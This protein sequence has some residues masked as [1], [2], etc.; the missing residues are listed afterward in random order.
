MTSRRHNAD[1][2]PVRYARTPHHV[3]VSLFGD[4]DLACRDQL[5]ATVTRIEADPPLDVVVDLAAV[6][7]L[8][9]CGLNF[10]SQLR[11]RLH[12]VGHTLTVANPRPTPESMIRLT[13]LDR[14]ITIKHDKRAT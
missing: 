9:S 5:E 1:I 6:T 7:F 3:R 11:A 12:Q 8:G 13:G 4:I 14:V 10:L 2:C